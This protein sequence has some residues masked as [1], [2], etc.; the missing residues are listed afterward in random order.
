MGNVCASS[1]NKECL[2]TAK[3]PIDVQNAFNN[4]VYYTKVPNEKKTLKKKK[5]RL[6]RRVAFIEQRLSDNDY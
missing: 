5:R 2:Y 6:M 4:C 1:R 3:N